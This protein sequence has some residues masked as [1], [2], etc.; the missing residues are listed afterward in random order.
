MNRTTLKRYRKARGW[1]QA[2]LARR[3][4]LAPVTV[5]RLEGSRP[6]QPDLRT[7]RRIA[8]ALGVPVGELLE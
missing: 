2:D 4:R 8:R 7:V 1:T 3:A 5:A 6:Q